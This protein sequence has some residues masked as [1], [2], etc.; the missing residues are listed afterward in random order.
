M[1]GQ[2]LIIDWEAVAVGLCEQERIAPKSEDLAASLTS[3]LAIR[4][5]E[6]P[7]AV[8]ARLPSSVP[9]EKP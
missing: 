2:A 9:R 8:C 6:A 4:D 5:R 7:Q 1:A 3:V